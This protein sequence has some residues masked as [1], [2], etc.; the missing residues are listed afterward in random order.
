[1]LHVI[2][3]SLLSISSYH[4][5]EAQ[6]LQQSFEHKPVHLYIGAHSPHVIHIARN[7]ATLRE[8][9][10]ANE[11][12]WHIAVLCIQARAPTQGDLGVIN[13]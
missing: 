5:K 4:Y 2:L 1:M 12:K 9:F 8:R 13:Y 11:G 3:H 7:L 6:V 10:A